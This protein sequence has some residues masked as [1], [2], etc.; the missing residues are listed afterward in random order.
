MKKISRLISFTA[1]LILAAVAC[2]KSPVADQT[3]NVVISV[4]APAPVA[5]AIGEG[6]YTKVVYFAAFVDGK[7]V[8]TLCQHVA[9]VDGRAVLNLPLV[10][11]VTYKCVFWAQTPFT[12]DK[13]PYYDL[14]TF[15]T[16]SKVK[17]SY[18]V[19]ANDDARDAFCATEEIYVD[20]KK[21]VDVYLR[22]PFA[23]V[24]FAASDY[25]MLKYLGLHDG[26]HSEMTVY[27]LPDTIC[28]LDGTVT[29]SATEDKGAVFAAAPIPSGDDEYITVRDTEYG[30]I[31]MNYV[32]ASQDGANVSVK[33][34]FV[35]GNATWETDLLSNVP[36]RSN[37]KTNIVGELFVEHG[38]LQIIVV[39]DFNTPDYV[40]PI[41]P[42]QQ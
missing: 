26:L 25:E 24:N 15:Y 34:R 4:N 17:V 38:Q 31:G 30:Y 6:D 1:A 21:N 7:S 9:L 2:Q 19:N 12:T 32:L 29:T 42:V 37:Y 13:M 36:I 20:G 11:N 40:K 8:P 10:K 23:Q 33:G 3:E 18:A 27:G 16:D 14:S 39:P 41:V 35:N 5:K 28:L 22:R